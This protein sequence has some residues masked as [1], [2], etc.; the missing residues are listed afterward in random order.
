MSTR[1]TNRLFTLNHARRMLA[2]VVLS[3]SLFTQADAAP[4]MNVL[5]IATDDQNNDIGCYDHPLVK[6]PHID[7]LARR[8]VRFDHAYCQYPVCNPSRASFL[9]GLYPE[10]TGVLNNGGDF[11]KKQPNVVTLP[12]QFMKQGYFVA[13][14]G[15]LYHYGVP[16]QIGTP[17]KDDPASWHVA[18]NPRGRDKD[19]EPLIKTIRPDS[20]SFGGTLSWLSADGTD[21][22]QTDTIG[23]E[24][25]IQLMR[26]HHPDKTG[27]PFFLAVG[28]YRPHTPYVAPHKY[29][30]LYPRDKVHVVKDPPNDRDD[31]PKAA[32]PDRPNQLGLSDAKKREIIQAY[33]ASTSFMD[34]QV[35]RLL[36]ALDELKLT[37]TTL[38]V[39]VSD[40]G[41]HLGRHGLWQKSD[42]FEASCRVPL[43]IADP[44][45]VTTVSENRGMSSQKLVE[46]VDL[47]P[48]LTDLCGLPKPAHVQGRSLAPL[49]QRGKQLAPLDE[50]YTVTQI[51][52]RVW[53]GRTPNPRPL[54][55]TIRTDQYRYTE[56]GD[57]G[58]FGVELYDHQADPH[59][60]TN[61]AKVE[62]H[63]A[64][65]SRLKHRLTERKTA[66]RRNPV[67]QTP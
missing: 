21:A 4:R 63:A 10:Q 51:R 19:D 34:A 18:V 37:G 28:F 17:G 7:R 6:T 16:T 32:L 60:Y 66:A 59:E 36:D 47:Y 53:E 46:L 57:K 23:A 5:F 44:R 12:Q 61:L 64:I 8:G 20:R 27:R 55:Y 33:H 14:V 1:M 38:V 24:A 31:I 62:A 2:L 30:D 26:D 49:F 13:R 50:A 42:L 9:T 54:G 29:F 41:Y 52:M 43:V 39:F 48:T 45:M 15:K 3:L 40:H 65:V 56:W 22:E 58:Q 35:G 67:P 25:A 11:R